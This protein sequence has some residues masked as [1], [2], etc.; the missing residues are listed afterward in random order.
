[1]KFSNIERRC[2]KGIKRV[3]KY[4]EENTKEVENLIEPYQKVINNLDHYSFNVL[5][6]LRSAINKSLRARKEKSSNA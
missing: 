5:I 2:I 4:W 1:M 6:E 3:C